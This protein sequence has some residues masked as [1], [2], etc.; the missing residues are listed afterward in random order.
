MAPDDPKLPRATLRDDQLYIEGEKEPYF[1]D[2]ERS[3]LLLVDSVTIC[4]GYH[5]DRSRGAEADIKGGWTFTESLSASPNLKELTASPSSAAR[6]TPR[7]RSHSVYSRSTS[8]LHTI[9]M[10]RFTSSPV[11][12]NWRSNS[13]SRGTA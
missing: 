3:I 7:C 8:R 13:T 4:E 1:R 12:P 2:P 9:G 6:R 5:Q 10:W 11:K